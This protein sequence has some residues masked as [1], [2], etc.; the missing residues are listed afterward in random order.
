MNH[1]YFSFSDHIEGFEGWRSTSHT[2]R[3]TVRVNMLT[4]QT[5]FN[6]LTERW[7]DKLGFFF[8]CNGNQKHIVLYLHY[9]L[10]RQLTRLL[11]VMHAGKFDIQVEGKVDSIIN[12]D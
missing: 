6:R 4:P 10:V 11:S 1:T 8:F 7:G 5:A 2:A 3:S 12:C 9:S